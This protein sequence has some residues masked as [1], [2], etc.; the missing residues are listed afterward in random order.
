MSDKS[1]I[2]KLA[3]IHIINGEILMTLSKGKETYYIS[4]WKREQGESDAQALIREVKE[5]LT[6]EIKPETIKLY[7]V[8]EA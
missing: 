7:G 1:F 6:V 8:F 3:Y 4:G 2:D 5:E